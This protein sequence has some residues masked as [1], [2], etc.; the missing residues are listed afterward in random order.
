MCL[1]LLIVSPAQLFF[2]V[3]QS[4]PPVPEVF[5]KPKLHGVA[6]VVCECTFVEGFCSEC[7]D[8]CISCTASKIFVCG[9]CVLIYWEVSPVIRIT[10]GIIRLVNLID[11]METTDD[12]CKERERERERER[13]MFFAQNECRVCDRHVNKASATTRTF[14]S[15]SVSFTVDL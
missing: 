9:A 12:K 6:F 7:S 3:S 8:P 10:I 4:F 15:L 14:W 11:K 5:I 2:L 13:E 1:S